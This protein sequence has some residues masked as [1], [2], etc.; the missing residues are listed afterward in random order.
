M[1]RSD[2][3]PMIIDWGNVYVALP[4]LDLANII[5]IDSPE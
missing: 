3:L 4:M 2:G 1:L 5:T